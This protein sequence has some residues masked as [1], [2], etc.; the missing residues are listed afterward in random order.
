M[1]W[2]ND[3][4]EIRDIA[5]LKAGDIAAFER[6][7]ERYSGVLNRFS[8]KILKS[9]HDADEVVQDTFLK[10]WEKRYRISPDQPFR[11]YL[12]TIALNIIRKRFLAK[13]REDKFKIGLYDELLLASAEETADRNFS[14]YMRFVE[15]EILRLPEKRKEIFILHKKEGLTVDEVAAYLNLSPKTIEN[16]ITAAIK[17]IRDGLLS[18]N[19]KGMY[20]L[21]MLL[22]KG[23]IMKKE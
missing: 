22:G 2:E 19:I 17:A 16:Q 1:K 13:A 6:L 14:D 11:S 20:F 15:E 9:G 8:K 21:T 12:F 10:I 3:R 4:E 18:K 7:F 5:L 23:I